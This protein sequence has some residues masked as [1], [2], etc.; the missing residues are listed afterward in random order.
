M[1][2]AAIAQVVGHPML[3]AAGST[4]IQIDPG[5]VASLVQFGFLGL[6]LI[7]LV[8]PHKYLVPRWSLDAQIKVKDEVIQTQRDDIAELKLANSQ[9]QVLTQEK[10]IPALVQATEVSRAYV[11]EL[12]RRGARDGS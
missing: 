11:T 2:R 9:L 3:M 8:G 10:M 1:I 6:V 12:A 4:A 7:D 5:F